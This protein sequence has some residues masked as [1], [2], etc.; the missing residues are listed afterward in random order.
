MSIARERY[1]RHY[2]QWPLWGDDR[3]WIEW[4][5]KNDR[6]FRE[7]LADPEEQAENA[8]LAAKAIERKRIRIDQAELYE[9]LNTQRSNERKP[10]YNE[11]G[12][13]L[14]ACYGHKHDGHYWAWIGY[15]N[16]LKTNDAL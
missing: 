10:G 3:E 8:A 9:R 14:H 11:Y 1:N 16:V 2:K 4:Q 5:E 15:K 12:V 6:L 7:M 13:P